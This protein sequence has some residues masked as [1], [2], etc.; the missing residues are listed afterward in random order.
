[1][2]STAY[3]KSQHTCGFTLVEVALAM[4]V[5]GIGL[6]AIFGLFFSA[7]DTDK[8]SQDDTMAAFFAE[9]V[10]SAIMAQSV[11]MEWARLQ[12]DI[13]AIPA[14][15]DIWANVGQLTVIPTATWR[16]NRYINRWTEQQFTEYAMRYKLDI[17]PVPGAL[18]NHLAYARLEVLPGEFGP[19][20]LVR[21][22]YVELSNVNP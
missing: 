10:M 1:M 8:A 12:Y 13:A 19:T 2:I 18:R 16:T 21:K 11:T 14:A 22:F 7:L 3:F 5:I 9:D 20:D 6:M 15:T 17:R 4:M